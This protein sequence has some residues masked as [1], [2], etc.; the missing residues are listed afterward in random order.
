MS[1]A[2][3]PRAV[4]ANIFFRTVTI[5]FVSSSHGYQYQAAAVLDWSLSR[6]AEKMRKPLGYVAGSR[7]ANFAE[8][9]VFVPT[10][11]VLFPV[12]MLRNTNC[13]Q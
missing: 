10:T 8:T 2:T 5:V 13:Q 4:E 11:I 12:G 9:G 7:K 3:S 1:K 6:E